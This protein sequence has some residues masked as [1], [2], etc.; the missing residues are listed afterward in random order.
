MMT[1]FRFFTITI[2]F[3]FSLNAFN[4][5]HATGVNISR[6]FTVIIDPGHG[7]KDLGARGSTAKEK[8]I[9][10]A[11][12]LLLGDYI[13]ANLPDVTII[14]TRKTDVFIP[15]NERANIA[16]KAKGD[17]FISIHANSLKGSKR[18]FGTETFTL[19]LSSSKENLE[20]AKRENSVILLEDDYKQTYEGFDPHS[21]ESYI[22]FEFMQNKYM[23]QSVT[24]AS[25]VQKE[26]KNTANRIDRGVKQAE[27]LV[28]R[29][30]SMPSVLIETGFISNLKE[31]AYLKSKQGRHNI[32]K[33]IFNAFKQYKK[34]YDR[35]LGIIT[36]ES[37]FIAEP[38]E[39][40]NEKVKET[41]VFLTDNSKTGLVYKIQIM[42]CDT[43]LPANSRLLKGYKN[44]SYYEENGLYKYTIGEYFT[45]NEASKKRK[46]L[47]TDFKDAFVISFKDGVKQTIK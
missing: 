8:D 7:G 41:T 13:K 37:S 27:F 3:I 23:D 5:S 30:T 22:M 46:S 34:E 20:V 16:N 31:E 19:G 32:A 29:K 9:N 24:F 1:K 42:A 14:F 6:P 43:K 2:S 17:L 36:D 44:V 11:I 12:A 47:L 21:S 38:S 4:I 25:E 28:L 26:F 35:K 15:L 45:L 18:P 40:L 39:N 33:C 10:L